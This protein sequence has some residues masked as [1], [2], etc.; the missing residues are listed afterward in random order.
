MAKTLREADIRP[1]DADRIR[2]TAE[3]LLN[4]AMQELGDPLFAIGSLLLAGGTSAAWGRLN[5]ADM[6]GLLSNYYEAVLLAETKK[7]LADAETRTFLLR[8]PSGIQ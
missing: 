4:L 5:Y 3:K 2:E 7:E 6:V 1:E 8:K